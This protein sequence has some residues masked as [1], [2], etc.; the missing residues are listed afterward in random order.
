MLYRYFY[1]FNKSRGSHRDENF[2]RAI[3]DCGSNQIQR[4]ESRVS[5]GNSRAVRRDGGTW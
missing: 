1:N 5:L 2:T 3:R 4:A